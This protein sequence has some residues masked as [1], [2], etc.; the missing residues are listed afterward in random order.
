MDA[1]NLF[2]IPI[3]SISVLGPVETSARAE[4]LNAPGHDIH[5]HQDSYR[6]SAKETVLMFCYCLSAHVVTWIIQPVGNG[7]TNKGT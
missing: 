5:T 6:V 3:I 7:D 2:D 1:G 4:L